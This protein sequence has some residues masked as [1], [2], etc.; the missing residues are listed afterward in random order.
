MVSYGPPNKW[1]G[2]FMSVRYRVTRESREWLRPG[3]EN[4]VP[5]PAVA[6]ISGAVE[7]AIWS[8]PLRI[9]S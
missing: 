3:S 8:E 9:K 2:V 6:L 5:T 7:I 1:P 4:G